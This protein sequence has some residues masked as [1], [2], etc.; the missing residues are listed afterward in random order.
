M[1]TTT[2]AIEASPFF[3]GL[4]IVTL[5]V[6]V[7]VVGRFVLSPLV[8]WRLSIQSMALTIPVGMICVTGIMATVSL[9]RLNYL[10]MPPLIL[11]VWRLWMMRSARTLT[12]SAEGLSRNDWL[13]LAATLLVSI[14]ITAYVQ[15]AGDHGSGVILPNRDLGFFALLAQEIPKAKLANGWALVLGEHTHASGLSTDNWYH[16]GP[17]WLTSLVHAVTHI[18]SMDALLNV[19][20]PMLHFAMIIAM[21]SIMAVMTR[22]SPTRCLPASA[23]AMLALSWPTMSLI[24]T[25]KKWVGKELEQHVHWNATYQFSYKFEEVLVFG[26]LGAFLQRKNWLAMFLIFAAGVSAP[27]NVAGIAIAA[28][29]LGGLALLRRNYAELRVSIITVALVAASW[30]SIKILFGLG[31]P[32]EDDSSMIVSDPSKVIE[33]LQL[34]GRDLWFGMILMALMLPGLIFLIRMR[35]KSNDRISTLGW[36][37]IGAVISGY[38]AYQFLLPTGER[39]H[40]TGYAHTVFAFPLAF[41]GL[42]TASIHASSRWRPL[43]AALA[44]GTVG[45]GAYDMAYDHWM[46]GTAYEAYT[47]AD[48]QKV[49][50]VVK[51]DKIGYFATEDRH[52]WIPKHAPLTAMIESPCVRLNMIPAKDQHAMLGKFYGSGVPYDLVPKKS[53][54]ND[55]VWSLRYAHAIDVKFLMETPQD[56]IPEVIKSRSKLL[57]EV[58]GLKFYS[59]PEAA[60]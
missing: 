37:G 60:N 54:E 10:S 20:T 48:L 35:D 57:I 53:G 15:T 31:L 19:V 25:L 13:A 32:K 14:L 50:D 3:T 22:W 59:V 8:G 55:L 1:I 36:L 23:M 5:L 58:P 44:L 42:V 40:F 46:S 16:W 9:G 43:F 4:C 21:A 49:K 41:C 56:L 51:G 2:A 52:W 45:V 11:L 38:V 34:L 6:F 7:E 12:P 27:H 30:A 18:S 26:A 33:H 39:A 17:I 28:A 24:P 29:A 47:D